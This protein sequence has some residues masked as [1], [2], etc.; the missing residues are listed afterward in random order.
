MLSTNTSKFDKSSTPTPVNN[1]SWIFMLLVSL[2]SWDSSDAFWLC[3]FLLPRVPHLLRFPFRHLHEIPQL[4]RCHPP[5]GATSRFRV[6]VGLTSALLCH[7][8]FPTAESSSQDSDQHRSHCWSLSN[9]LLDSGRDR[10]EWV[11]SFHTSSPISQN[12]FS[13]P[14]QFCCQ[15]GSCNHRHVPSRKLQPSFHSS[16]FQPSSQEVL[17]VHSL[18]RFLSVRACLWFRVFQT[19]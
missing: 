19:W 10:L 14:D 12:E 16:P 11:R 1:M 7:P 8:R 6:F 5:M 2:C 4:V 15:S 13:F 18:C 17:V 3:E 9:S